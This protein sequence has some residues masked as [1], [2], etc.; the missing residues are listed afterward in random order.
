MTRA[1]FLE[2]LTAYSCPP[3]LKALLIASSETHTVDE[4]TVTA[5]GRLTSIGVDPRFQGGV[6][7][8]LTFQ[9]S[10]GRLLMILIWSE[11]WEYSRQ[12]DKVCLQ[13]KRG[14]SPL[15]Q[16]QEPF[17]GFNRYEIIFNQPSD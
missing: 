1:Q 8:S 17:P 3:R 15:P 14:T 4:F 9:P 16:E 6:L 12:G 5:Q 10:E 11:S 2:L 13:R 7:Y